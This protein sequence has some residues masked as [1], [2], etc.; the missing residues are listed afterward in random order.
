M[1]LTEEERIDIILLA[2]SGDDRHVEAA[3]PSGKVS[4]LGFHEGTKRPPAGVVQKKKN[5]GLAYPRRVQGRERT[6]G[7]RAAPPACGGLDL[8]GAI[9]WYRHCPNRDST[10]KYKRA[11]S[12]NMIRPISVG[13]K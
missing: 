9:K 3:V 1:S 6:S 8:L 13:R 12:I 7:Q 5:T 4:S 11:G 10:F 2:E